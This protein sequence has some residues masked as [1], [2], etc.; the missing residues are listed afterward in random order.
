M[1]WD[2]MTILS[3]SGLASRLPRPKDLV[4]FAKSCMYTP[5]YRNYRWY[6]V[7]GGG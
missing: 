3:F 5:V 2:E 7:H 4:E 1:C 6:I